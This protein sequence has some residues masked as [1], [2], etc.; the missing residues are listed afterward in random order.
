MFSTHLTVDNKISGTELDELTTITDR[1]AVLLVEVEQQ[2]R[3][4]RKIYPARAE[5]LEHQGRQMLALEEFS[6]ELK[7]PVARCIGIRVGFAAS[8]RPHA[9]YRS[10]SAACCGMA[11]NTST[12]ATDI[13]YVEL[14]LSLAVITGAARRGGSASNGRWGQGSRSDGPWPLGFDAVTRRWLCDLRIFAGLGARTDAVRS[15][16]PNARRPL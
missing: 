2:A 13:P 16:H 14:S 6:H 1:I 8:S 15:H 11:R 9:S 12:S 4:L 3:I 10:V 5:A 7:K